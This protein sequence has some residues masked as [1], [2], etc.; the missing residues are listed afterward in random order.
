R[1][2]P[3]IPCHA[4]DAANAVPNER[5]GTLERRAQRF[6]AALAEHAELHVQRREHLRRL[7]VELSPETIPLLLVLPY[8]ARLQPLELPR[9]VLEAP[10]QG[11]VGERRADLLTEGQQEAV[12]EDGERVARLTDHDERADHLVVPEDGERRR[13]GVG[14]GS[15]LPARTRIVRGDRDAR[16]AGPVGALERAPGRALE[17][18]QRRDAEAV[19][20]AAPAQARA[21]RPI[22]GHDRAGILG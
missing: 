1:H 4:A 12:V 14:P 19:Y 13:I 11:L 21:A 10:V 5:L 7:V 8:H 17:R 18:P 9:P 2:R 15:P 3:K 16:A 22:A 20:E 6:A